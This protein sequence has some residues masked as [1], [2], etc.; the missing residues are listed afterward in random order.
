MCCAAFEW[1]NSQ[2]SLI[3][4]L[5]L[6][7]AHPS[8]R[9]LSTSIL[10]RPLNHSYCFTRTNDAYFCLDLFIL[11][12]SVSLSLLPSSLFIPSSPSLLF[13]LI[14]DW[15]TF[16]VCSLC[17]ERERGL[18]TEPICPAALMDVWYEAYPAL[19]FSFIS[20]M[21][22][23]DTSLLKTRIPITMLTWKRKNTEVNGHAQDQ[24]L[25]LIT[26]KKPNM[27]TQSRD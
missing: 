20:V 1:I 24:T 14:Y 16:S 10:Q 19:S 6:S 12:Q 7:T 21:P 13:V 17:K 9:L 3:S 26:K 4:L 25:S 22:S 15:S 8:W 23:L 2:S 18:A 5:S 27:I 11:F